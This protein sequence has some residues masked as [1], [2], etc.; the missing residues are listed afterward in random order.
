MKLHEAPVSSA[1]ALGIALTLP[2]VKT[3]ED[4]AIAMELLQGIA[5]N[6][7]N[8]EGM[9]EFPTYIRV[10]WLIIW[11]IVNLQDCID[12]YE[13]FVDRFELELFPTLNKA[14]DFLDFYGNFCT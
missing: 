6:H 4:M 10:K 5:D 1:A 7:R 2:V 12:R 13:P 9:L 14:K 3:Q 8:V 11:S